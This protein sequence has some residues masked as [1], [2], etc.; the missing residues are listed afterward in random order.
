MGDTEK[1]NIDLLRSL[2]AFSN[3][4]LLANTNLDVSQL[5]LSQIQGPMRQNLQSLFSTGSENVRRVP[6]I[7]PSHPPIPPVSPYSQIP[8]NRPAGQQMNLQNFSHNPFHSR[9]LSQPPIFNFDSTQKDAFTFPEN[10]DGGDGGSK[11][12]LSRLPPS[13][14]DGGS[15]AVSNREGLPPRKLH[16]RSMSDVPFGFNNGLFQSPPLPPV[17]PRGGHG[18]LQKTLSGGQCGSSA[19]PAQLIKKEIEKKLDVESMDDLLKAYMSLD[20][21][22]N[23]S[24]QEDMDSRASNSK[25]KGSDNSDNDTESSANESGCSG[26]LKEGLKRSAG[27]DIAP[28][29]RHQRSVS[30]DSFMGNLQLN[31]DSSNLQPSAAGALAGQISTGLFSGSEMEKIMA[32]EKLA[33]IAMNDPK[34]VKRILA[35]RQSAARSKERK[36]RYITELEH[37][38]QTLQNEATTLSAQVTMLQKDSQGLASINTELKLRLIAL[39]QQSQIRNALNDALTKEIQRLRI[40]TGELADYQARGSN[41]IG[42]VDYQMLQQQMQSTSAQEPSSSTIKSES[43]SSHE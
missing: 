17:A 8:V 14:G 12:M 41:S 39:E 25:T 29:V 23:E 37:K 27:G 7:P 31:D 19:K 13:V 28:T 6:G 33:E 3:H 5:N 9:S 38:V 4:Q 36:M 34:R 21:V 42:F 30:M 26:N 10:R 20:S 15:S 11:S 40:V 22:D 1:G 35:N 32:N 2:Q 16:R 18:N 24:N 43:N